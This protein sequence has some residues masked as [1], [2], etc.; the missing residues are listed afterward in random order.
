MLSERLLDFLR[1][2]WKIARPQDRLFPS[3]TKT[4]HISPES[5][6][7]VFKKALQRAGITKD[8]TPH[9]L[10]HSFATHLLEAGT[11]I[12]VIQALLGHQSIQ[13]TSLY[14]HVSTR[15]LTCTKSP[16]DLLETRGSLLTG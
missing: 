1:A 9:V 11:D 7:A 14:T 12:T 10:R 3:K 13:T 16:L 8:V 15:H 6:R 2:Y 4:G 5:V